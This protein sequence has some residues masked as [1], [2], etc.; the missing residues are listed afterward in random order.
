MDL[1]GDGRRDVI[2][3]SW[4]GELYWFRGTSAGFARPLVL[5]DAQAR[6]IAIG[7]ASSVFAVDWDRDGDLDLVIGNLDGMVKWAR[8]DSGDR[9]LSF[10]APEPVFVDHLL[11]LQPIELAGG[12]AA[13]VAADWDGDGWTDLVVGT[14]AGQV[15]W[16]RAIPTTEAN[17]PPRLCLPVELVAAPEQGGK[18]GLRARPG[19]ADWNGDG[20]LDLL[21]GDFSSS[22]AAISPE[23]HAALEVAEREQE[24]LVT[25]LGDRYLV[26]FSRLVQ[27]AG[28]IDAA[29][30]TAE[31][32]ENMRDE[33]FDFRQ[34]TEESEIVEWFANQVENQEVAR[35][36]CLKI[37]R[38][39]ARELERDAKSAAMGKRLV[40]LESEIE[41]LSPEWSIHGHVWVYLREAAR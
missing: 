33:L 4:P 27:E 24:T 31:E 9:T 36:L 37:H 20:L 15:V 28:V 41:R 14:D 23:R 25:A 18:H 38:E 1:D 39:A 11:K 3:G 17:V 7:S 8:N 21:V 16:F 13:P 40:E 26:A 6:P 29:R 10:A 12:G 19:V 5:H 30:W 32:R 22:A 35:E 2:S 34:Y